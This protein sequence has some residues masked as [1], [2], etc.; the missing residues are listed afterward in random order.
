[1]IEID[2]GEI[3]MAVVESGLK[4]GKFGTEPA[5]DI[6][7]A[8]NGDTDLTLLDDSVN[9]NR[10]KGVG[11]QADVH[12]CGGLRIG[13]GVARESGRVGA[14]RLRGVEHLMSLRKCGCWAGV[15]WRGRRRGGQGGSDDCGRRIDAGGESGRSGLCRASRS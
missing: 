7:I 6:A 10:A 8:V 12:L 5:R 1:M 2:G 9:L 4:A 14:R 15:D 3:E 11:A 13:V